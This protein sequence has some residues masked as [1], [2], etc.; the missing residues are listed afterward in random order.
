M[1]AGRSVAA[2]LR[3]ECLCQLRPCAES[4]SRGFVR[5]G[6]LELKLLDPLDFDVATGQMS[7]ERL[8]RSVLGGLRCRKVS[9]Q[10]V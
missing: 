2:T 6:Y 5:S 7:V 9:L 3:P 10:L 4:A 8:K 1:D